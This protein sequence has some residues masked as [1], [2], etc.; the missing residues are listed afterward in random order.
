[1]NYHLSFLDDAWRAQDVWEANFTTE[2]TA[3]CWMWISGGVWAQHSDWSTMELRCRRCCSGRAPC[4][5]TPSADGQCCIARVP[6]RVLKQSSELEGRHR[7]RPVILTVERDAF[8]AI[9][10]EG[11]I[12]A[13]GCSVASFRDYVSAEKWLSAN[14][15]DAAVIDVGTNDK[16]CTALAKKLSQRE[17]PFLAVSNFSGGPPRVDQIF[18][19]VPWFEK[20][21]TGA[22]LQLALR[23][24]L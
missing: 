24:I 18:G 9:L 3:I 4:P 1:M 13:A 16:S 7:A 8:T 10:Q 6:A 17:I 14:C 22:G 15:P 23:S 2:Q 20:P 19:P 5:R 12:A 21:M 11:M